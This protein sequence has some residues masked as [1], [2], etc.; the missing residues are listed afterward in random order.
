MDLA[1]IN[2]LI[3]QDTLMDS[4]VVKKHIHKYD[5]YLREIVLFSLMLLIF[6]NPFQN[7]VSALA[8]IFFYTAL[9]SVTLLL[10]FSNTKPDFSS[11]LGLPFLFFLLW[12]F[13][14]TIWSFDRENTLHDVYRHLLRYLIL[15]YMLISFFA[16]KKYFLTLIRLFITST[17]LFS[18]G[19]IIYIYII[20]ANPISFRLNIWNIGPNQI[21]Q[22]CVFGSL[23]SL[24]Y[25][26]QTT[27]WHEKIILLIC[28]LSTF[29][30]IVLTYSRAC[31]LAL[32]IG[33]LFFF[34]TSKYKK[35]IILAMLFIITFYIVIFN[36]SPN[37]QERFQDS[38]D[39]RIKI[40]ATDY[41][42]M[43]EKPLAG[44]GYGGEAFKKNFPKFNESMPQRLKVRKTISHAHNIFADIFIRLGFIGFVLFGWILFRVF[45]MARELITGNDD[46][47]VKKW[48]YGSTACLTALLTAGL[49]GNIF[50]YKS[51][52]I[53]YTIMAMITILWKFNRP[54]KE[55][56]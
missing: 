47:F 32:A 18:L 40:Y 51:A 22:F 23:L 44:S 11:P 31:I 36:L 15:Y 17:T 5:K 35:S 21:A 7:Y 50:N 33:C 34:S 45:K 10:L 16:S 29:S 48:G 12:A 25:F 53:F 52:V 3:V 1:S 8:E 30:A 46:P 19:A 42:M 38:N 55:V 20:A 49:F 41:A 28:F 27:K 37:H 13:A 43:K 56:E 2:S 26:L 6:V 14:S 54:A 9:V 24:F 4:N 39:E